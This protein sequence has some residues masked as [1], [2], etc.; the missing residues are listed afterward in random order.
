MNAK[1]ELDVAVVGVTG[2]AGEVM[3]RLLEERN[4]PVRKLYALASE[5]SAG[6]TILFRG[7]AVRVANLARS[8]IWGVPLSIM[9]GSQ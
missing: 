5:R 2:A 9:E 4:F 3:L 1:P 7:K 6:N 8:C